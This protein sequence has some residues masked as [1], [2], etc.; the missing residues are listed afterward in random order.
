[1]LI[2]KHCSLSAQNFTLQHL[3]GRAARLEGERTNDEKIQLN[4]QI[5]VGFHSLLEMVASTSQGSF[6][7]VQGCAYISISANCDVCGYVLVGELVVHL[8]VGRMFSVADEML[9]PYVVSV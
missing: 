5:T 9:T 2:A 6:E 4:N 3:E 7:S 8:T 1:M